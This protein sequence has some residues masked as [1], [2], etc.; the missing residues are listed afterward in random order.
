MISYFNENAT[1]KEME[2]LENGTKITMNCL[3]KDLQKYKE[4][5]LI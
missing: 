1:V 4:Y 5:V 2:Y 3:L